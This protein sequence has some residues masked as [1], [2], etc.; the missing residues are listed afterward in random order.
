LLVKSVREALDPANAV[1]FPLFTQFATCEQH[2]IYGHGGKPLAF[3]HV[4]TAVIITTRVNC[5]YKI[6]ILCCDSSGAGL[7]KKGPLSDPPQHAQS[8]VTTAFPQRKWLVG[9]YTLRKSEYSTAAVE[10]SK[11]R[12]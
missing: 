1:R 7:C 11:E 9:L 8:S 12:G 3:F 2:T 4:S 6:K 10:S 5:F